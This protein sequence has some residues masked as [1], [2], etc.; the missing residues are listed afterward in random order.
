MSASRASLETSRMVGTLSDM[1][2]A[3]A[4]VEFRSGI[5]FQTTD[6]APDQ[7]VVSSGG[8]TVSAIWNNNL[9]PYDGAQCVLA[10]AKTGTT[11][12]YYVLCITDAIPSLS[13]PAT[14]TAFT[15]GS[16]TCTVS[17]NGTTY[18]AH[19]LASY[20]P[21][22]NDVCLILDMG[23]DLYAVGS[24]TV[25]T[26]PPKATTK[27]PPPPPVR[28]TGTSLYTAT[29][30]GTWTSAYGG[31]NS[32]FGQNVYSGSG[33]V[34]PSTGSWFYSGHTKGVAGKTIT[35]IQ[36]YLPPRRNAGAYNSTA[37]VHFYAHN[38][39]T[40]SGSEP[41]RVA[42][43]YN[44]NVRAHWG[45]GYISLPGSFASALQ[46]GGGISIAGDPYVGF[47]GVGGLGSSG[48]LRIGWST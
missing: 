8:I 22:V 40:R 38:R 39:A 16:A 2:K 33:Y 11:S 18:T 23:G 13:G 10:M 41:T 5:I 32:Y 30:S 44:L 27:P 17:Q 47:T 15:G 26:P 20:T 21:T 24:L 25:Y 48:A 1:A 14:V 9:I 45:G 35:S 43:P 3:G 12:V 6:P 42:G 36:F 4:Q 31:W 28:R 29:D 37:T 46:A 19:R 34:P 7:W